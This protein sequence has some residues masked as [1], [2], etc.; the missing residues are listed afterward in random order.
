LA[1][2]LGAEASDHRTYLADAD[3]DAL[4]LSGAVA[5]LLL[6]VEFSARSPYLDARRLLDTRATVL[7]ASDCNPGLLVSRRCRSASPWSSAQCT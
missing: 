4:A 7:L 5:G 6:A 3:I 2:E 1:C